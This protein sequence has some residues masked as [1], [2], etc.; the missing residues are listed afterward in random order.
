MYTEMPPYVLFAPFRPSLLFS[1]F[2]YFGIASLSSIF[3]LLFS[4]SFFPSVTVSGLLSVCIF[5]TIRFN[6]L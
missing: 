2:I 4:F 5:S 1:S 3:F 6:P